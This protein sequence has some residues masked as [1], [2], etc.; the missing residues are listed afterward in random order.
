M[1]DPTE[2][3]QLD[4]SDAEMTMRIG[5]SI[6]ACC[7]A[8]D[9]IALDGELGAGKTQFVRGLAEGLGFDPRQVSSP[10]FVIVQEY[11]QPAPGSGLTPGRRPVTM[12]DALIHIDAYRLRSAGDLESIGWE[13]DGDAMREGAVVAV[14]WASLLGEALPADRLSV[15]IEHEPAGRLIS[16]IAQGGW[17]PRIAQLRTALAQ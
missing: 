1:A 12:I 13:G 17:V 5:R 10:T 2:G 9:V 6:G 14:E 11:D 3:L 8:G 16:L 4:S 7:V 15:M